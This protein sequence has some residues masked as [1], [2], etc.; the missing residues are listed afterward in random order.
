MHTVDDLNDDEKLNAIFATLR[1][2]TGI[3]LNREELEEQDKIAVVWNGPVAGDTHQTRNAWTVTRLYHVH[4]DNVAEMATYGAVHADFNGHEVTTRSLVDLAY[5]IP[6]YLAPN[7]PSHMLA[8]HGSMLSFALG[9]F[10]S[11]DPEEIESL[12]QPMQGPTLNDNRI[13]FGALRRLLQEAAGSDSNSHHSG[14][15]AA[16]EEEG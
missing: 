13:N 12:M 9:K 8:S 4:F 14:D 11:T 16:S 5:V 6:I 3:T 2:E 7:H 10:L 1:D 15:D